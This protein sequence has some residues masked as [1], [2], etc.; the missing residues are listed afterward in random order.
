MKHAFAIFLKGVQKEEQALIF[1]RRLFKELDNMTIPEIEDTHVYISLVAVFYDGTE[2]VKFYDL[3][4][5]ADIALYRSKGTKG[6]SA[7]IY[8]GG[9]RI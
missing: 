5:Q 3:Y 6:Y 8:N 1:F 7:N 2:G 4:R 9:E